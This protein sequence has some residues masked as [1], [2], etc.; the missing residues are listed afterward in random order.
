M[1]GGGSG[2]PAVAPP[3]LTW[4]T[5][6][7]GFLNNVLSFFAAYQPD[8]HALPRSIFIDGRWVHLP[9]AVQTAAAAEHAAGPGAESQPLVDAAASSSTEQQHHSPLR[10]SPDTTIA[11]AAAGSADSNSNSNAPVRST[12]VNLQWHGGRALPQT[13]EDVAAFPSSAVRE[14]AYTRPVRILGKSKSGSGSGSGSGFMT[15]SQSGLATTT[16]EAEPDTDEERPRGRTV[17]L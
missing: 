11:A 16:R 9:H 15:H 10:R 8:E 3:P 6:H 7:Q 4:H 2:A 13:A 1:A 17:D 14:L 12:V 5:Y